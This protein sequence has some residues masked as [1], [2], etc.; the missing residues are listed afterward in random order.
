MTPNGY[1]NERALDILLPL[2]EELHVTFHR[3]FDKLENQIEGYRT[4]CKSPQIMRVLTSAGRGPAPAA[5]AAMRRM[6]EES[7]GGSARILAGIGLTTEDP[8]A[9][10]LRI[11]L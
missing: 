11:F 8:R 2:T 7:E 4:F 5:I 10:D 9:I 6:V 1:I 3:A